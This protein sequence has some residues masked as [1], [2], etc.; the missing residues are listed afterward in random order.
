MKMKQVL[1]C[2]EKRNGLNYDLLTTKQKE[3]ISLG[4]VLIK[5]PKN[6][7]PRQVEKTL[8]AGASREEILD[9]IAFTIGSKCLLISILELLKSLDYEEDKRTPLISILDDVREE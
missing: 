8:D 5:G 4:E 7:I 3:L 2:L 6:A 1:I 9:I